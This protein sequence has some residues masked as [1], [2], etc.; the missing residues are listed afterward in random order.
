MS[1]RSTAR[2]A[3]V[4]AA[5]ALALAASLAPAHATGN[6]TSEPPFHQDLPIT[7]TDKGVEQQGPGG[8][9]GIAAGQDGWHFV[10]PG[11][12][13]TTV[14]TKLT[15]TFEP[16]GQQVITDFGPPT[17]KHAYAF[18]P[19][20]AKLV[21]A[22]AETQG[23]PVKFFN[24]SHTCPGTPSTTP[25]ATTKPPTTKPATTPPAT[26]KPPATGTTPPGTSGPSPSDTPSSTQSA[27]P[28]GAPSEA[29]ATTGGADTDG[30][31]GSLASTGTFAVGG[32]LAVAAALI[33]VGYFVRRRANTA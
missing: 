11:S 12:D 14:F 13:N 21:A 27:A 28:S 33:G 25:P 1:N 19:V 9:P 26:S 24:L 32:I 31:G 23:E 10:L 5:P 2:W 17:D 8:C 6:E 22:S 16:G 18:S 4:L 15:V 7:A 30:D 29:P 3:V 20:G